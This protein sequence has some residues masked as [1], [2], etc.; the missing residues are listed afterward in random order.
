MNIL[1]KKLS[2]IPNSLRHLDVALKAMLLA[3]LLTAGPIQAQTAKSPL[4]VP[5]AEGR[6]VLGRSIG[7]DQRL[8]IFPYDENAIY[9]VLTA[10]EQFTVFR[11]GSRADTEVVAGAY[12]GKS[13]Q[14]TV[15]VTPDKK[16]LRIKPNLPDIKD[17]LQIR[18]NLRDYYV[19]LREMS[20]GKQ[21]EFW[22][23]RV[24]WDIPKPAYE[25]LSVTMATVLAPLAAG[26]SGSISDRQMSQTGTLKQVHTNKPDAITEGPYGEV[27]ECRGMTVDVSRI[28]QE[29][30]VKGN[31]PFTPRTPVFDNGTHTFVRLPTNI[32]EIPAIFALT[33]E[34]E[35]ELVNHRYVCGL[36]KIDRVADY[37]LLLKLGS[38][39]V[40]IVRKTADCGWFGMGCSNK[41]NNIT[42]YTQPAQ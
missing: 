38:Q 19:D 36:F 27:G 12:L 15:E 22:Y 21:K 41:R 10:V 32:Q 3:S 31:A 17:T 39:E 8:V 18:T 24:S 1:L 5:V 33:K 13:T 4:T 7:L 2:L 30:I 6:I 42:N 29:Y 20:S 26:A 23:Q 9:P 28:D 25:D 37:G 14:W 11:L 34:G 16:E 40:T 35:A